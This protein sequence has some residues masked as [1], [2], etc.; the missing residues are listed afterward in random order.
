MEGGGGGDGVPSCRGAG[1]EVGD[2]R[3]GGGG[4]LVVAMKR[5][6]RSVW[7]SLGSL[8][9]RKAGPEQ[10]APPPPARCRAAFVGTIGGGL[11]GPGPRRSSPLASHAENFPNLVLKP[12][13]STRCDTA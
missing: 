10:Q 11:H 7:K 13:A 9:V 1:L 4:S 8:R 6:E 12:R 5:G 3:K 2:L